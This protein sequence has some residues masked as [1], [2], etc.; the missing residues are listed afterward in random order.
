LRREITTGMSAPPIGSTRVTPSTRD[1]AQTAWK[2]QAGASGR[3]INQVA[4]PAITRKMAAFAAFCPRKTIAFPVMTSSS[5]AQAIRLPERVMAPIRR[6][7]WVVSETSN[8]GS[9]PVARARRNSAAPTSSEAPPPSPF[10]SATIWGIDVIFTA[11]ASQRPRAD[12][13]TSPAAIT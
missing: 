7:S 1:S 4:N 13:T 6:V 2:A 10:S 3:A 8:G 11:R 9:V 5:L 12:P